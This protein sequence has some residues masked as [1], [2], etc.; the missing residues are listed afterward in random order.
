M[1]KTMVDLDEERG[2]LRHARA[3]LRKLLETR[4]GPLP[5]E[6]VQQIAASNDIEQLDAALLR[7][8]QIHALND[9]KF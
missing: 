5:P 6:L 2:E 4:F 8:V 9:F 7:L 3:T 1:F